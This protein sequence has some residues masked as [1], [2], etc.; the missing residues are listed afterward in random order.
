[1]HSPLTAA[2]TG[3]RLANRVERHRAG[4]EELAD[5]QGSVV[6]LTPELATGR[7][8]VAGARHHQRMQ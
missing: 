6:V 1:M 3:L 4:P 7:E 5:V 2:T 8:H